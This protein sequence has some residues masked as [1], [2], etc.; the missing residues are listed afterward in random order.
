MLK[1]LELNG[2]KSFADRTRFEFPSGITAIVGPN[3]SGKSNVVDAIKWVLGTQSVKALRGKEMTDVIFSGARSRGQT[4]AAEVTLSFDNS[5][6]TLDID[7]DEVHITRRVYRSGEG[8]Y[9]INRQP[10][11]LRDIREV[12][13]GTGVSTGAY[14]IIEQGKVDAL[15]QSSPRERRLIFE[16][17][18]GVSRFKLKRQE[19]ARRLER[20]DQNLLRLSDIV[21]ELD[22]RLR[23]VRSQA[24]RARKYKDQSDR[25]KEL[26]TKTGL[27]DWHKLTA[28]L[29]KLQQGAGEHRSASDAIQQQ[30]DDREQQLEALEQAEETLQQQTRTASDRAAT[31]REQIAQCESTRRSQSARLD[32]LD[33]ETQRMQRQLLAMSSRAGV[34]QQLVSETDQEL[35]S[36]EQQ[37]AE[38]ELQVQSQQ[39]AFDLALAAQSQCR[40]EIETCREQQAATLRDSAQ[41]EKNIHLLGSQHAD[42]IAAS[43]RYQHQV[44]EVEASRSE[45]AAQFDQ[46]E[47][48]CQQFENRTNQSQQALTQLQKQLRDDRRILAQAQKQLADLRGRLSG[49]KERAAVLEELERRLDGLSAGTKEVLRLAREQP[50]GPFGDVRGIVADLLR[51]DADTAPLVEIALGDRANHLLVDRVNP[52]M[53]TWDGADWPGRTGFLRL[54]VPQP[55]SAVDRIDLSAEPGVMGRADQFVETAPELMTLPRRLLGRYWFVDTLTTAMRLA[56]GTGRGLNYVTVVGEVVGAD[57]TLIVGPAQTATGLLSRRSELRALVDEVRDMELRIE[58]QHTVNEKLETSITTQDEQQQKIAEQHAVLAKQLSAAQLKVAALRERLDQANQR[59]SAAESE[60]STTEEQATRSARDLER[61][62]KQL[63]ERK[64]KLQTLQT[65]L[66]SRTEQASQLELQVSSLQRTVTDHRVSLA[67]GEQRRDGLRRQMDQLHRDRE[68]HD[69]ALADTRKRITECHAQCQQLTQSTLDLTSE[70]A[71]LFSDKERL[72]SELQQSIRQQDE[73]RKCKSRSGKELDQLRK[74]L[75]KYQGDL[76]AAEMRVQQQVHQ[77]NELSTRLSD[78]YEIDLAVLAASESAPE[79]GTREQLDEEIKKLRQQLQNIGPV[80]L[81]ALSELEA[82]EQRHSTLSEQYED[83]R[84]AKA[85]LE[86]L[87]TKINI[88]SREIFINSLDVIRGHFQ[89]LYSSLF[90]GGEADIL[91]D[92]SGDQDVLECGIEIIA[93]PPGKQPRSISLLSGGERTLTCVALLLAIFRSRPSPFCVL[94]EVDA[95]LDEA[96]IDRFVEVLKQFMTSTQFVVISHSKRTMACAD[97]LYGITMQESGVS[98]RVSVR[99]EDVSTE[100]RINPNDAQAA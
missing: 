22:S 62:Q 37:F 45:V 60:L 33:Q 91:V 67:R 97:T 40:S 50:E 54:D 83:L 25:L 79:L 13:A 4:N 49:A 11:R 61:D 19:A 42:A 69:R 78:D 17:A 32:E 2:F 99:F 46:T 89:E 52:A 44:R 36:A 30:V 23:S 3:G 88:E 86:Q 20:V 6:G 59:H 28:S 95:A 35:Q 63:D 34:T 41:L 87:V 29:N 7:A 15:L 77:R 57:G 24:G 26:R 84:E 38:L 73:T 94:D 93:R 80:N 56:G 14:S 1:A 58:Q 12:F 90:G 71:E 5:N 48:T 75:L 96:N 55:A 70:I 27:A 66:E 51:V 65:H 68:E 31:T 81:E 72:A 18:A 92:D 9:L 16:E 100:G 21:D 82:V 85:R 74:K 76:Q 39:T 43:Q 98:K 64:N 10:V 8:E 47:A 53:L